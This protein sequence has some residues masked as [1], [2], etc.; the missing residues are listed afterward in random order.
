MN[1]TPMTIST[2]FCKYWMKNSILLLLLFLTCSTAHSQNQFI[3]KDFTTLNLRTGMYGTETDTTE[4][5]NSKQKE[6]PK[7]RSVMFKSLMV[8]GWGQLVNRQAW[9]LP[10]IYGMYAGVGYFTYTVHQDYKDYRAAF[11]NAERGDE[12]DFKFGPTPE[13]LEGINNRQL[14]NTRN[15][16]RNR[17]DLMFIVLGLAHGLNALDAYVFAHMRS[18]DVSDDL[19]AS[20][21]ISP[22]LL[23]DASPG[24]TLK[25]NLIGR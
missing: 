16:L 17:R 19:S 23:T 15:S 4:Q 9:K 6:F 14:R 22:A 2:A 7:P 11:Y 24:L 25:I 5:S 1:T 21:S 10:I 8:P 18:F 12:T 20:A 3:Q 13:N